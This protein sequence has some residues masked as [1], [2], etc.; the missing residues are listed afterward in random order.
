MPNININSEFFIEGEKLTAVENE[1]FEG[2]FTEEEVKKSSF[3]SY[4]D[5]TPGPNGVSFMFY[6]QFWDLIKTYIMEMF[7]D[8]FECRLD[9]YR[10]NLSLITIIR[11][12]K[13]TRTMNK[14]SPISLLNCS[15]KIFTMVHGSGC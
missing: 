1:I 11:K 10:L 15:Y 3:D 13:D 4:S 7:D 5:G 2:R 8:F 9:L 12:E 6:Q 14:F